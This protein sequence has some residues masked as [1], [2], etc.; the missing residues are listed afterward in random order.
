MRVQKLS[1]AHEAFL[2]LLFF[3]IGMSDGEKLHDFKSDSQRM[4][5][6]V[7]IGT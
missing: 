7:P 6:F 3:F 2:H 5:R 1:Y 4:G